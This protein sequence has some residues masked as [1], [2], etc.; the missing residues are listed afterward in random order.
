[1]WFFA[2]P[3]HPN[4][5]WY[6]EQLGAAG[7]ETTNY[8]DD[9]ST[10]NYEVIGA[11]DND[12]ITGLS[13]MQQW[14]IP[15]KYHHIY[16]IGGK[17]PLF[18]VYLKSSNYGLWSDGFLLPYMET[19]FG[20]N[21]LGMF[22]FNGSQVMDHKQVS[23]EVSP[24]FTD[25][26]NLAEMDLVRGELYDDYILFSFPDGSNTK[27]TKTLALD[28]RTGAWTTWSWAAASFLTRRAPGSLDTL[29]FGSPDST[30]IFVVGGTTDA[31]DEIEL[32]YKSPFFDFGDASWKKQLRKL[33]V[34]GQFNVSCSLGV[35]VYTDSLHDDT[36][37]DTIACSALLG[38]E[39]PQDLELSFPTSIEDATRISVEVKSIGADSLRIDK[40]GYAYLKTRKVGAQ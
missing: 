3:K 32:T 40:I 30:S 26:M 10:V 12:Q 2:S 34:T 36:Y 8:Y 5:A 35:Y 18:D 14:I 15:Y 11:A 37:G 39:T 38:Y 31:G 13:T 9:V 17:P 33:Y 24:F 7:L 29:L 25:S 4:T 20:L 19:N 21:R 27:N 6:S 16:A 22:A 23:A 28:T 1:M